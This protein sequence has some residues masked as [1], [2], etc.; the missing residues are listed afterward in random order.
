M[1]AAPAVSNARDVGRIDAADAEPREVH[2]APRVR[3]EIE[4]DAGL[5]GPRRRLPDRSDRDVVGE[6]VGV[7]AHTER[8]VVGRVG[9]TS[10][11]HIGPEDLS[12]DDRRQVVLT[13]VDAVGRERERDVRAIVDDE[14]DT[15]RS[16]QTPIHCSPI[17]RIS[18]ASASFMRSWTRS[19]PASIT[20]ASTSVG[21]SP[22]AT[23]YSRARSSAARRSDGFIRRPPPDDLEDV[24]VRE[25]RL[26]TLS[27]ERLAVVL[28]DD[29]AVP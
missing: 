22:G 7:L 18:D 23:R 26:E 11:E 8:D 27:L 2:G 13:E 6:P 5:A 3:D 28:D 14:G 24:S 9:R 15:C 4:T 21:N 10:D 17:S 1:R 20:A 25:R 12:R 19:T 29:M 16:S